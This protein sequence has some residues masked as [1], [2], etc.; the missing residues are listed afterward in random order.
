[1]NEQ[2][3]NEQRGPHNLG[4]CPFHIVPG[5]PLS[6]EASIDRCVSCVTNDNAQLKSLR[7][8]LR[9]TA[10]LA[11]LEGERKYDPEHASGASFT[12]FIKAR[13]CGRLWTERRKEV[14]YLPYRQDE[15]CPDADELESNPLVACLIAGACAC[16]SVEDAVIRKMEA[17][18]LRELFPQMLARLTEKERQVV[19]LKYFEYRSGVEIADALAV[20]EGRV[21]QL[22]KSALIKLKKAYLRLREEAN[23]APPEVF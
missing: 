13:V 8:D 19:K 12:T 1:M 10:F 17:E 3:V 11:I 5:D 2:H 15:E 14:R 4:K 9:Q 18:Q 16:E 22:T 7:E 21:S 6:A 23:S 20:S